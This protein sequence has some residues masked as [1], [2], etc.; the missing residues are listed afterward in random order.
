M[1][2]GVFVPSEIVRKLSVVT[3]IK[4]MFSESLLN[5]D[6]NFGFCF[7]QIDHNKQCQHF[8]CKYDVVQH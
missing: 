1:K 7:D 6:F 3:P 2:I 5:G 8:V 4:Y